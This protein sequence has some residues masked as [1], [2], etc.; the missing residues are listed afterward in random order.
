MK[1]DYCGKEFERKLSDR[2]KE[3]K[4][5]FCC[6]KCSAL[7]QKRNQIK[8]ICKI[9][10]KEY[11]VSKAFEKSQYCSLKCK[12]IGMQKINNIEIKDDYA[13]I[14][15]SNKKY[16]EIR[17]KIDKED[18]E[19][20]KNFKFLIQEF[21]S[22]L[23]ARSS[24]NGSKYLHQIIMNVPKGMCIDHINKDTT[25]NR[26]NNLRIC[27]HAENMQN[28]KNNN[29]CVGVRFIED[30]NKYEARITKNGK[31]YI[32]GFF[33]NFYDAVKARKQGEIKYYGKLLNN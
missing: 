2:K 20:V 23:Y 11:F 10:G 12:N 4:H 21:S 1:C 33:T 26:K 19:K 28:K 27:T 30:K 22:G 29:K 25:D 16:S 31:I 9:C 6:K 7:Y 13:E 17:F 8:K 3:F 32:L 24:R 5:H 18:I 14:I 15:I